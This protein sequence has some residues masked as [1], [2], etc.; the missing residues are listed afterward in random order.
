LWSRKAEIVKK[1][2]LDSSGLYQQENAAAVEALYLVAQRIA[3]T[4]RTHTIAEEI[5]LHCGKDVLSIM[6]ENDYILKLQPLSLSNDTIRQRIQ[7]MA[8]DILL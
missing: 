4:K 5:I 7:D 2:R 3:K 1:S 6:T 8:Y